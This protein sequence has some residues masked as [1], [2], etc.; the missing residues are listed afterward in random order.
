MQDIY[1]GVSIHTASPISQNLEGFTSYY[2]PYQFLNPKQNPYKIPI[3]STMQLNSQ[4][5]QFKILPD[6][7]E[8]SRSWQL[9]QSIPPYMH[10]KIEVSP[11]L[12]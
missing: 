11:R 2:N 5:I 10:T 8:S 3:E 4:I 6:L 9:V 7:P 1:D 12:T